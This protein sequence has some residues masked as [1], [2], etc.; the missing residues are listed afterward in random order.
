[1]FF[2]QIII[3]FLNQTTR[4]CDE[5]LDEFYEVFLTYSSSLSH[6]IDFP[7]LTRMAAKRVR[8][9]TKESKNKN[10]ITAFKKLLKMVNDNSEYILNERKK[11]SI[12]TNAKIYTI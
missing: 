10:H 7:E 2:I 6:R 4:L 3:S 11:V 12:N 9:F 8:E 5:I 1:M